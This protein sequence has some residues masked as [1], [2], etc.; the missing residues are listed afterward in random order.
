MRDRIEY[1]CCKG[2]YYEQPLGRW[3]Y[4]DRTTSD[5]EGLFDAYIDETE[6]GPQAIA[7]IRRSLC[8]EQQRSKI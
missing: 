2:V 8:Y 7:L 1:L 6:T 5:Q 4:L 3:D